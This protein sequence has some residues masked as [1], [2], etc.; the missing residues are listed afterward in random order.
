[1]QRGTR[2]VAVAISRMSRIERLASWQIVISYG[3]YKKRKGRQSYM[4]LN[5]KQKLSRTYSMSLRKWTMN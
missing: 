3:R 1:M 5:R 4:N 2:W